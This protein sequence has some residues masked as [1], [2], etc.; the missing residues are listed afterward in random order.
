MIGRTQELT[1]APSPVT[2]R[3]RLISANWKMNHN[4]LEAIA[5]MEK[6]YHLLRPQQ[7]RYAELSI[8]P[9]FVDLRSLQLL[10]ESDRM[11]F[12]LG[13]QNCHQEVSGAYTGEVSAPM[14]AKLGVGYVIVGHSE[15]R[16]L[17]G[18]SAELVAQKAVAV[19]AAAMVPIVCVGETLKEREA[20]ATAAVIEAQLECVVAA[21]PLEA[22]PKLVV[23]YEPVWAI[24]SG[25]AASPADAS[26]AAAIVRGVVAKRGGEE[27][28]SKVRVQ[29]GGSVSAGNAGMFMA[30]GGVDGLLVG[31]ASLEPEGYAQLVRDA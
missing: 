16:R 27:A 24:G 25:Q 6:L 5:A 14:L 10:F 29:Y 3:V 1:P 9:P 11:P 13:A 7:F 8:H 21:V 15:R 18:E 20:G 17:F 4:H 31:T 19:L 22:L 26:E 12:V 23:A 28:S 30:A 2:G